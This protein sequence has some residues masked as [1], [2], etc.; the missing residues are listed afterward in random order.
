[1]ERTNLG[2]PGVSPGIDLKIDVSWPST[3][4]WKRPGLVVYAPKIVFDL[5]LRGEA[6]DDVASFHLTMPPPVVAPA[7]V[8]A[9]SL[10]IVGSAEVGTLADAGTLDAN[11]VPLV[12]ARAFDRLYDELYGLFF[13]GDPRVPLRAGD[14]D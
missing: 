7:Q 12:T 14:D 9:R 3:P 8:R 13:A 10:F 1:M 6:I 11:V 4:T 2:A 5:T